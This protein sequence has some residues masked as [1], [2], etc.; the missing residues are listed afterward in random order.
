MQDWSWISKNT[1]TMSANYQ[2]HELLV[3]LMDFKYFLKKITLDS[4][5]INQKMTI[6]S[7]GFAVS[8]KWTPN[9]CILVHLSK[10]LVYPNMF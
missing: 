2:I 3:H 10:L 7:T 8:I 4:V 1:E 5:V 9:T 6:K